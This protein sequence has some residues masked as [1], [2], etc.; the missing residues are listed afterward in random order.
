MAAGGSAAGCSLMAAGGSGVVKLDASA[1]EIPTEALGAVLPIAVEIVDLPRHRKGR[2]RLVDCHELPP[3]LHLRGVQRNYRDPSMALSSHFASACFW[4]AEIFNIW[5]HLVA[6]IVWLVLYIEWLS[7]AAPAP[8]PFIEVWGESFAPVWL[9]LH[10]LN[11]GAVFLCSIVYHALN[12]YL[13]WR[14]PLEVMDVW[15]FASAAF[16]CSAHH[17]Q[18]LPLPPPARLFWALLCIVMFFANSMR[19][20]YVARSESRRKRYEAGAEMKAFVLKSLNNYIL[21]PFAICTLSLF[22]ALSRYGVWWGHLPNAIALM[23]FIIYGTRF[24]ERYMS[25]A[26]LQTS[27][28]LF[29][30]GT[31]YW[32]LVCSFGPCDSAALRT[33]TSWIASPHIQ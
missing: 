26:S 27:H 9:Q 1:I 4:H 8:A 11:V 12:H 20:V 2:I 28:S 16:I 33:D 21:L 13:P 31:A 17:V 23:A 19:C 22:L 6:F 7:K 15:A 5:S 32:I 29:H 25:N 10:A 3:Y 30:A 14:Y 24:P 18:R